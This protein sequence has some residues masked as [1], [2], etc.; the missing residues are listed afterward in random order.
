MITDDVVE[1][2]VGSGGNERL[3]F[4]R[5]KQGADLMIESL[6]RLGYVRERRQWEYLSGKF[7]DA[8]ELTPGARSGI[9]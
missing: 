9:L 1:W 8:R 7:L 5:I 6:V 4:Q 3:G 2:E